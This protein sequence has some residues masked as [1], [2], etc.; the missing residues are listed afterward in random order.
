MSA[1]DVIELYH[2]GVS[3]EVAVEQW[4]DS[5]LTARQIVAIHKEN[6]APSVSSG[7]L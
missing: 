6:I 7:W 4:K 2:G 5:G 1:D 3:P